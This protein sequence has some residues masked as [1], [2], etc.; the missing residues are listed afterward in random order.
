M[1]AKAAHN[2]FVS[3]HLKL[4]G[5]VNLSDCTLDGSELNS[6]LADT[7]WFTRDGTLSMSMYRCNVDM[8]A[9]LSGHKLRLGYGWATGEYTGDYNTFRSRLSGDDIGYYN[10]AAL[11]FTDWKSTTGQDA[12]STQTINN[13]TVDWV[14]TTLGLPDPVYKQSEYTLA[15]LPSQ[16]AVR[17][18]NEFGYA[19]VSAIGTLL[20]YPRMREDFATESAFALSGSQQDVLTITPVKVAD[21]LVVTAIADAANAADVEVEV[22]GLDTANGDESSL[23]KVMVA[24]GDARPLKVHADSR[25]PF[26]SFIVRANGTADDEITIEAF[27]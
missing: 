8:R 7:Y 19:G 25:W 4:R 2:P 21:Q 1:K 23:V 17:I 24:A 27:C 10:G 6:T 22:I 15:T 5:T 13:S 11:N 16:S 20:E 3:T 14:Q 12:N 26:R 9:G 18:G